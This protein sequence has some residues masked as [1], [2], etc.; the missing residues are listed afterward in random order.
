MHPGFREALW[1]V[2][3]GMPWDVAFGRDAVLRKAA[4]IMFQEL[5]G[6]KFD[7]EKFAWKD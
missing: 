5:D 6:R 1:C 2:K 7:L 3:N 4:S